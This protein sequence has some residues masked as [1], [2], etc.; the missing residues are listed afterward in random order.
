MLTSEKRKAL[1]DDLGISLEDRNGGKFIQSEP[2]PDSAR[3]FVNLQPPT[4]RNRD[5]FRITQW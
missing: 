1:I 2:S 5:C 4:S 3:P